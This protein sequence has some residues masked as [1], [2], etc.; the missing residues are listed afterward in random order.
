VEA[1]VVGR[2]VLVVVAAASLGC[3]SRLEVAGSTCTTAED[4][5]AYTSCAFHVG[6][7]TCAGGSCWLDPKAP[8]TESGCRACHG[9]LDN[10]APPLALNG[11][12]ST[13]ALGVGAHQAHLRGGAF[14]RPVECQECH[15]VPERIEDP[16]HLD[17]DGI[18]EV[19]FG[20]V[21]TLRRSLT[22]A[23][24]DRERGTCVTYCHGAT[25]MGATNP[26]PRWTVVDGTEAACGA[27]HGLPPGG[28]HPASD[29]CELCHAPTAGPNL[30][31]ADPTTHVDGIVQGA[32]PQCG[33]CHGTP[34]SPAPPAGTHGETQTTD[35]AVG[36]HAAHLTDGALRLALDCAECHV[37]PT[38]VD[39]PGHLDGTAQVTFGPLAT[40][41]GAVPAWDRATAT[42]ARTYCHGEFP[43]GNAAAPVWTRVDGTQGA[44]GTCH[45][46]PPPLPHPQVATCATCHPATVT[47]WGEID[48]VGGRHIDGTVDVA[49]QTCTSC[50]GDPATGNPAPPTGTRGETLTT[51]PAVG[52][53]TAHLG[54]SNWHRQV[55]CEDCHVVPTSSAHSDGVATVSLGGLA[56]ADG[57]TPQWSAGA[58]TCAG[59][60]C[61]G[62]TL[63]GA[64]PGGVT[65][66]T[67]AWTQ[68]DGTFSACGASCHTNPPGGSHPQLGQCA[69]C[70]PDV[71][72][73][74]GAIIA[75]ARHIDGVV[76]VTL[77]ACGACHGSAA[78][79]APPP[80]T[81][82]ATATTDVTV[83]A[84][85][86]H[87]TDG[88]YRKALGCAEC[89]VVPAAVGDPGH[90]GPS[91]AEVTFGALS[92]TG[93]AVPAWNRTAAT[94]ANT[95]CHGATL[96]GATN[97]TPKWTVVN[98]SQV[99]CTTCH[100]NPPLA[101][102]VQSGACN[103]CHPMTVTAAGIIDVAGGKH[104]DGKVDS[105]DATCTT[106][107]GNATTGV[108]APPLGTHG[109]TATTAP[110]VGAHG[111]HL[112]A[113]NWHR[114]G[115]CVDC[116]LVPSSTTHGNGTVEVSFSVPATADGATPQF[117]F[118]ALT[119]GNVYCHGATLGPA[120]GG[121]VVRRT[122]LWTQVD[123][124]FSACGA[125][126]H[127][128]PPGG[129]HPQSA[130][131]AAC[132]GAV[133]TAGG[134]F[135][136]PGLHINGTVEVTEPAC[137]ACHGGAANAA[138]PVATN[139]AVT[140]A[141]LRVGAHQTH[142]TAGA[143]R[144]AVPCAECHVV[145][146]TTA[147]A[148]HIDTAP[149]EV[150]FGALSRTGGAAPAWNRVAGTCAGTYCHGATLTGGSNTT[151][152]WTTVNGTQDACGSC[153]GTP[154]SAPHAQMTACRSCHPGTV[155]T[156]GTSDVAGGKHING[157]V[158]ATT[159]HPDPAI[160]LVRGS[161]NFHGD[162][163]DQGLGA[164]TSCHG[165]DLAG[166]SAGVSCNQCHAGWR[167]NCSFC[168]GTAG[169]PAGAPPAD[170]A[171]ATATT[172]VGVGAHAAHLGATHGISA[173]L[174]CAS[175]HVVPADALSAGHIDPRPAEVTFG[176][177]A[178]TGGVTPTWTHAT[179]T[180]AATYCHGNFT[181]GATGN[182]PVWTTVNG[183]A[184]ACTRCHAV[185]PS[186]GRHSLH[187]SR[188]YGCDECHSAEVNAGGTAILSPA[189]HVNGVKDVALK[190]GGTW[191]A[192]TR[193]CTP[194]CHGT[195]T[196]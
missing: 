105:L 9:S 133:I 87:L 106:C 16:S 38:R 43:G 111:A 10:A 187:Q 66:R 72:D 171:G 78:N 70:H 28:D 91:P 60:Y 84:H 32:V 161:G 122:P 33:T 48:A 51:Q 63:L 35:L 42:C 19:T 20:D 50:H 61:H 116:H 163:A 83:G 46:D 114:A 101:P 157:T 99:G 159:V 190:R 22:Q 136:N 98:G 27:C 4:C 138:P 112:G 120:G 71:I 164:C 170:V 100:G 93:G 41:A 130:Q 131:C 174:L 12:T 107:H 52:A 34:E 166:G 154:P 168:H 1:G 81:T 17:G 77:P 40:A 15:V 11:D 182:A 139:G 195:E 88:A 146:T 151:P 173:R 73:A 29:R 167:T 57:A 179:A 108:A 103:T 144:Q 74:T 18:A 123:G 180:C 153:H 7:C 124:S 176:T 172:A 160:W 5:L 76:D 121:G 67:P 56:T 86:A 137:N 59:T 177:L 6:G 132:H 30:T 115:E 118:S 89:H 162:A 145:P 90:L 75:P 135:A 58:L 65:A 37:V 31:I 156:S 14:S 96:P 193:R 97:P 24:W 142:L 82:G 186:T 21:G 23:R 158:E 2:L 44:C 79:P 189:L 191:T 117:S 49:A 119:C 92:R 113:S 26:T 47:P 140:T 152:A 109:E 95:Y 39:A 192:S 94:C 184:V 148:G 196:W 126:C 102:H 185:P 128:N 80:S 188:S 125:S 165:S 36:A 169:D 69:T 149:A 175:C 3:R 68:V 181:G 110:A 55:A 129:S 45:G 147:Q 62:A 134:A 150:T 178:R 104:I 155:T 194:T 141:D 183:S 85:A 25:L 143:L 127:T 64:R 54:A 13:G 53:H 8:A